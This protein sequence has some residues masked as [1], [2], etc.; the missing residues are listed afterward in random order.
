MET[1]WFCLVAVM[2]AM[3][4]VFDGFD[5]GAGIVHLGV[6]RTDAERRLVLRSIGPVWDG[7][8]VWLVAA[9]GTLFAAF[10]VLYATSFSG[11]YLPLMIVLWLLILRGCSIEFRNHIDNEAWRPFW[12]VV[13][14][15]SSSLL[16]IF[17]GAALGNVIRGVPY[18]ESG[19]FFEPLWTDFRPVGE[20][21]ILDWYTILVGLA[22]LAALTM[23]GALWV[24]L[25]THD[26][27]AS[28]AR[29]AA[30]IG[31]VGTALLTALVTAATI[32]IQPQVVVNLSRYPWGWALPALTLAG[33]VGAWWGTL[34]RNA[35]GAFLYSAA[36]LV[37]MLGSAAF[38]IYPYVLP[39]VTG[40]ERALTVQ[41]AATAEYG[42][43]VGL[44]WW[45]LGM[46][47]VAVYFTITY[48]RFAGKVSL[49]PE[50][51]Y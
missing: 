10:P 12:D 21:G 20:T 2:I 31:W 3:Y 22:A 32:R 15:V 33:L 39:S 23:H 40:P 41:N 26:P 47:L 14:A 50:E 5:L 36:Y 27:V 4:V 30:R 16:A 35:R 29:R 37:G 45:L 43:R 44:A 38:G 42:L 6:A 24:A 7:N 8:E 49:E 46:A 17:F 1:L 28:R 13:F 51:G 25:K 19:R 48:R 34:R 11:F 18:D 9:G